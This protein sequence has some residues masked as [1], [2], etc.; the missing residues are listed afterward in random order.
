MNLRILKVFGDIFVQGNEFSGT[1]DNSNRTFEKYNGGIRLDSASGEN[2]K[3]NFNDN[4][5]TRG[6]FNIKSNV[7][8]EIKGDLYAR[9]VYAGNGNDLSDNSTLKVGKEAVI[10]NDLSVKATNTQIDI[11]DFYGINDKTFNED[12]KVRKSSSI[13]IND[14]KTTDTKKYSVKISDKAYI[15]GVAHINT[16]KGYQTGESVAVKGNYKAYGGIVDPTEEFIYD[17]PLQVLDEGNVLK[18]ADHFY[19]Y[20]QTSGDNSIDCGGVN[21][22]IDT[23]SIGAIVNSN[24]DNKVISASSNISEVETTIIRPKRLDYARNVYTLGQNKNGLNLTDLYN[25]T[26]TDA[27]KV[28]SLL[29]KIKDYNL[30]NTRNK[31]AMF[32][33]SKDK[34]IIIE[35]NKDLI[36]TYD[37][38]KNIVID[39]SKNKTIK[40]VI[41]TK[42]KVIIDGDVNFEGNIIAN[43]NL[44]VLGDGKVNIHYNKN[45]TREIQ[46]SNSKIFNDVFN[47]VLGGNFGGE[48][49]NDESL[50]IKSNSSDFLKSKL[51]KI[52]Q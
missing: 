36:G 34:N 5:F 38:D 37:K 9:N 8:V 23:Y 25:S 42:G 17:N 10:D 31:F 24:S 29:T 40:A 49:L 4:V 27:E 45:M 47:D 16:E 48:E 7:D 39:A 50:N 52:I 1:I 28:S 44:E 11:K 20:W 14:Y 35:G 46:K 3:I 33:S 22:P 41:V 43:G 15:M 32:C 18:K 26:G 19:K 51:W 6:T 30:D 13:I 2:R 12:T 21:L